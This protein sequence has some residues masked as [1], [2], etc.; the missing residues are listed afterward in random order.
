[1]TWT[2]CR[3]CLNKQRRID[4]LEEEIRLLKDRLRYQERTIGEGPFGSSTPSSKIPIKPGTEK[5][6]QDRRGGAK[7]GHKGHGR[8]VFGQEEADRIEHVTAE[9]LCP[10]CGESLIGKGMRERVVL[11]C[12]PVEVEKVLY[13]LERKQCPRCGTTVQGRPPG[14]LPKSKF[15]NGLLAHV[16]IEHYVHG[17]TL[18]RL[19][20][21]TGVGIGSLID[22]MHSLARRLKSV[23]DELLQC[24]RK[25]RVKH[26]DE[27]GWRNNGDNGYAWLFCTMLISIF[28]L[29]KSRSSAVAREVLGKKKLP[30]ILVVD[31]YVAYNKAPCPLQYCY[32]HL[33]R[34]VQDIQSQFPDC[35]E[36]SCFVK[37][38]APLL[39]SAMA[40]RG[41][42][43]SKRQFRLSANRIKKQIMAAANQP[44]Q[45][46]AIQKIQNIFR[47]KAERL[48]HWTKDPSIPAD[49][50]LAERELRP[51]VIARKLSFGSQSD[52]GARTREVL[53]TVLRTLKKNVPRP[54]DTLKH[55]LNVLAETPHANTFHLLFADTKTHP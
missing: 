15:G 46:P 2:Y 1:V 39:A 43:L 54:H 14:V 11:D 12:R 16:A 4:V 44:A 10:D 55:A 34:D 36:V 47:E 27:T 32:A 5:G 51:L 45:H 38:V 17:V 53:M 29:R 41:L 52:E 22:A 8:R 31:R 3:E 35:E 33:L 23:S 49:N 48:F 30:G 40:L 7:K 18:G 50:N 42:K 37:T 13:R 24:Y 20:D 21:Q 9:P 25:A 28:R 26:A 6:R 19:A